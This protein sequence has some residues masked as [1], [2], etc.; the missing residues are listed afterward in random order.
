[1][2]PGPVQYWPRIGC[3]LLK[4]F[5]AAVGISLGTCA[6]ALVVLL[7][8]DVAEPVFWAALTATGTLTLWIVMRASD[9]S[10]PRKP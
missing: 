3:H 7:K 4:K 9:R 8:L 2:S 10:T 1:M 6:G 5:R